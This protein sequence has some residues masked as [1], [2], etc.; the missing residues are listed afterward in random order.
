MKIGSWKG[1]GDGVDE[2]VPV[3]LAGVLVFPG[4]GFG[5]QGVD[6]TVHVGEDIAREAGLRLEIDL[7]GQAQ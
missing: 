5:R 4:S 6:D 7:C 1:H 2:F 3:S